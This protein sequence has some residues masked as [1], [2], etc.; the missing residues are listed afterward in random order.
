MPTMI[1]RTDSPFR[2]GARP[3]AT[4]IGRAM[5]PALARRGFASADLLAAWPELVGPAFA[6]CSVPERISWPR[7]SGGGR[8]GVLVVRVAGGRALHLQH[9]LSV[10][11]ERINTFLGFEAIGLIRLIQG[12]VA[13]GRAKP[14]E[15]PPRLDPQ[16]AAQIGAEVDG[17]DDAAL[18]DAL[19]KLGVAVLGADNKA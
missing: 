14:E 17:V 18:R 13:L 12:P 2:G 10:L 19:Y 7:A 9:E 6:G 8:A 3:L 11:R 5:A 4:L 16:R 1:A 15:P